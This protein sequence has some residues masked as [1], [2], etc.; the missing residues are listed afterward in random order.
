MHRHQWAYEVPTTYGNSNTMGTRVCT[1][2]AAC[3]RT[4]PHISLHGT[5]RSDGVDTNVCEVLERRRGDAVP[6]CTEGGVTA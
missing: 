2:V 6:M 3:Q 1:Q 5:R 4:A